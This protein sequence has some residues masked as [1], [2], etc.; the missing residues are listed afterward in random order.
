MA[1]VT[2]RVN[3]DAT[4]GL[5]NALAVHAG[6]ARSVLVDDFR[7]AADVLVHPDGSRFAWLV[8]QAAETVSV[9][10]VLGNGLCLLTLDGETTGEDVTLP[11]FGVG[12]F[13]LSGQRVA[14]T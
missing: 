4:A 6:V 9:K 7:V 8:S 1:A 14:A 11:P 12:V 13:R 5:Y 3:P 10:P 2:P